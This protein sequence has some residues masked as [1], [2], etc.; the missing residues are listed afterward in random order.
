MRVAIIGAGGVGGYLAARLADA[1]AAEVHLVARGSHLEALRAEG[2]VLRSTLG[3]AHV[4]TEV[5]GDTS[6]IGPVDVVVF[7]V[8]TTD[9]D[10]ALGQLR[11][12]IGRQ[13]FAV[14]F[15]NG[16]DNAQRLAAAAGEDHVIGGVAFIFSTIAEPG[17]IQH[18][19]GPARFVFGEL[20]GRTTDRVT[21]FRDA[22]RDAGIEAEVTDDIRTAIWR[23]FLFI[24]AHAGMTAAARLPLGPLRE[25]PA[26]W[27]MYRR[28]AE[29]VAAVAAAED[30]GLPDDAVETALELAQGLE[31]D[32]YSSLHYD[33]EHGKPME[34]DSLNGRVVALARRHGLDVPANEAI[35]AL[36]SPWAARNQS[37][38]S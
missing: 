24:C 22:C 20:D 19:G 23:K 31:A 33:L 15:Q 9:T 27:A 3:D 28:V 4:R 26:G 17:V 12:L 6:E 21:Q 10:E 35:H 16:V 14:S 29:E 2:L 25:D 34:L 30:V 11:P 1:D 32:S 13:T 8:K 7:A 38:R 37:R 5:T 18:T 36:L